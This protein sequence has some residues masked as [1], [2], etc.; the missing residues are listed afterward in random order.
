[1]II[2]SACGQQNQKIDD[3]SLEKQEGIIAQKNERSDRN[4]QVLLIP[5]ISEE[6]LV[7]KTVNQIITM[8]QE[9]NGAYYSVTDE[10]FDEIELGTHVIIYWN[11]DQQKSDP[12]QRESKKIEIISQYPAPLKDDIEPRVEVTEGD[13]VYRLVSEKSIYAD[14]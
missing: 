10:V 14:G 12:P 5:N 1:M 6:D 7:N 13:F 9:E 3:N 11:G 4:N 2:L 8:A